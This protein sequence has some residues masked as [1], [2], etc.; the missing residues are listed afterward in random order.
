VGRDLRAPAWSRDHAEYRV[1]ELFQR[2]SRDVARALADSD[3]HME[4]KCDCRSRRYGNLLLAL[5]LLCIFVCPVATDITGK[6]EEDKIKSSTS[7]R[8]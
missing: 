5:P 4:G 2:S 1:A 7:Q 3:M 6:S 8:T